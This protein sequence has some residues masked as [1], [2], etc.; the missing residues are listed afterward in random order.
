MGIE[1]LRRQGSCA[2]Y[3][4]IFIEANPF[5]EDLEQDEALIRLPLTVATH[6]DPELAPLIWQ[7][8]EFHLQTLM[9]LQKSGIFFGELVDEDVVQASLWDSHNR[10]KKQKVLHVKNLST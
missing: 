6:S 4:S 5:R 1:K 10:K 9:S 3:I 2:G 8:I 7:A